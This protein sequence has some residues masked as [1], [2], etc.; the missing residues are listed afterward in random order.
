MGCR[1]RARS[2]GGRHILL[3]GRQD[4]NL[5]PSLVWL[6]SSESAERTLSSHHRRG[7]AGWISAVPALQARSTVTRAAPF[8]E[9]RGHLPPDRDRGGDAEP[10]GAGE[11]GGP[12]PVP[13]P[14]CVQGRDGRD[15]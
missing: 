10:R 12:Q 6:T 7:G 2:S 8:G 1:R 13:L 9:G 4:G 5:L 15:A 14:S 3:L 11:A